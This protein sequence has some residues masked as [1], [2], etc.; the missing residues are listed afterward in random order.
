MTAKDIL[1]TLETASRLKTTMRHCYTAPGR[2]ES[3][4]DHSWRVALMAMLLREEKAFDG[5][6]MD[7]VIRMA[8]IHDLGEIFTGD[9]PTFQKTESDAAAEDR[10]YLDWVQSFPEPQRS[11]WTVLLQ[12][13]LELKSPEAKVYKALD[14]MEALISH[15]E[16]ELSTWLPL[17][18]DLQY[19][20]GQR[21]AEC[22]GMLREIRSRIDEWTTAKIREG[23]RNPK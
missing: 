5:I 9:I 15:N 23:E 11:E 16:S 1:S 19:S 21:E 17:E 13:M 8:L 14:K 18:Y 7:R 4:A 20:Y 22:N 10:L 3:V 12:E 6:D 2:T